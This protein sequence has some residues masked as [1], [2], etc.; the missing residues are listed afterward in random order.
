MAT[1]R[2]TDLSGEQAGGL[3]AIRRPKL[4]SGAVAVGVD[5]AD[6][7][8]EVTRDLLGCVVAFDQRE[9]FALAVRQ[10]VHATGRFLS[11]RHHLATWH[12]P[13]RHAI[14]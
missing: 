13:S 7:D 5:R 4:L 10:E 9:D 14:F 8:A 1:D 6:A 3:V 2:R 12:G 11:V